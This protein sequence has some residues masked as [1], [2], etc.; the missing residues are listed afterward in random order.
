[1]AFSFSRKPIY[2]SFSFVSD[3]DW[4]IL[5]FKIIIS[6]Y[7]FYFSW[8]KFFISSYCF[9]RICFS[10]LTSFLKFSSSRIFNSS[11]W[12]FKTNDWRDWSF[13]SC[14]S[15]WSSF[16]K[17]TIFSKSCT[18]FLLLARSYSIKASKLLFFRS[19]SK[20]RDSNSM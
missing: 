10:S 16:I 14:L 1:M 9:S 7:N 2:N 5:S 6:S 12:F 3:L 15:V 4:L 13:Y 18:S 11:F 8:N 20:R 19:A 17:P